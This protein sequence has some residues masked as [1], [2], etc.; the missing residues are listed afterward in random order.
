MANGFDPHGIFEMGTNSE[1]DWLN[2]LLKKIKSHEA[3]CWRRER[4]RI[5]CLD[6][7]TDSMGMSLGKRQE[8]V[9]DREAWCAAAHGVT[10]SWT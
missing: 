8:M 10:E 6:S 7:I 9:K 1:N 5:K 3:V 4:Q 2:C